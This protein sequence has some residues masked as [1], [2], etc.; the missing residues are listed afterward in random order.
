[1]IISVCLFSISPLEAEVGVSEF[2]ASSQISKKNL[3][4]IGLSYSWTHLPYAPSLSYLSQ[5]LLLHSIYCLGDFFHFNLKIWMAVLYRNG[6]VFNF[7][8]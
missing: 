8:S 1:M 7:T 2:C 6:I 3:Q 4:L 5:L